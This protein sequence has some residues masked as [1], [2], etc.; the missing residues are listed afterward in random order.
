MVKGVV[1]RERRYT[2]VSIAAYS[3]VL[4]PHSG[5]SDSRNS[6]QKHVSRLSSYTYFQLLVMEFFF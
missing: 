4:E 6:L 1:V 5:S 2:T 3:A